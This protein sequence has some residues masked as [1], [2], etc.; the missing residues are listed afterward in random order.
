MGVK[1]TS[2]IGWVT[3][4]LG[5]VLFAGPQTVLAQSADQAN[6]EKA[7]KKSDKKKE[8]EPSIDPAAELRRANR[9]AGSGA[10][11]RSVAHYEKVLKAAAERYP[12]AYYNLAGVLKAK[13]EYKRALLA[14]QAYKRVGGAGAQADAKKGINKIKA[15]V[16]NKK[17]ASLSVDIEPEMKAKI[18]INGMIVAQNQD[19]EDMQVL[20][21]DYTVEADVVDHEPAK[22]TVTLEHE[23]E[24]SVTLEPLEK[25]YF[26][27][28]KVSVNQKGATVKFK[29]KELDA[30]R[31]P[32]ETVVKKSPMEESAK[33]ATGKWLVEVTKDNYHKWVRYIDVRRDKE[34]TVQVTMQQKLPAEI[35]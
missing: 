7:E 35:R 19:I 15:S 34:S 26:G 16:W 32:D 29:A 2:T 33:L 20:A 5:L 1:A 30:P 28:A 22:K 11:T 17:F 31:A 4:I 6:K 18:V 8:E 9:L 23:G 25:V 21:G 12:S 27:T 10:L 14:Y 3:A 24:A 13:K